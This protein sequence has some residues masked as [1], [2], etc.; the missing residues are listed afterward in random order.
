MVSTVNL[1]YSVA[2]V[3]AQGTGKRR[4]AGT[5]VAHT[6][7]TFE[8]YVIIKNG[9]VVCVSMAKELPS[10]SVLISEKYQISKGQWHNKLPSHKT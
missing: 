2:G 3:G 7:R 8:R 10:N 1:V 9:D 5:D 4:H 6:D